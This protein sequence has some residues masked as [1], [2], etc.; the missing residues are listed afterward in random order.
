MFSFGLPFLCPNYSLFEKLDA[1]RSVY[2]E[3]VPTDGKVERE[4]L[5]IV[6]KLWLFEVLIAIG[7]D[8]D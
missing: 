8:D 4:H 7:C 3:H 2:K 5:D 1:V 6:S